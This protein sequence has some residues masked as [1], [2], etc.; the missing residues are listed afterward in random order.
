MI[1]ETISIS[2]IHPAFNSGRT[3]LV[4]IYRGSNTADFLYVKTLKEAF[5]FIEEHCSNKPREILSEVVLNGIKYKLTLEPIMPS[6]D[7][8]GASKTV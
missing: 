5:D 4:K 8:V 3:L 6:L 2:P 7:G 1:T